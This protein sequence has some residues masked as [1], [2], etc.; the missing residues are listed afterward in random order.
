MATNADGR[1]HPPFTETRDQAVT[2]HYTDLAHKTHTV[3]ISRRLEAPWYLI[4]AVCDGAFAPDE[5]L[6]E[7]RPFADAYLAARKARR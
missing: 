6:D 7:A 4:D 1:P 5:R 2:G 3:A